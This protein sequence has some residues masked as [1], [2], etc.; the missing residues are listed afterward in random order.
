MSAGKDDESELRARME[1]L[2]G[3]IRAQRRDS[4]PEPAKTPGPASSSADAGMSMAMKAGSEFV[5]AIL[6]GAALG[7]GL[8]WVL[9]TKPL[10]LIVFFMLGV[11]AG[12]WNVIRATSPNGAH[13]GLNS[14]LSGAVAGDKD[15]PRTPPAGGDE[16]ED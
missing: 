8:D 15:V 11:A 9:H 5:A 1:R 4:I 7:W 16:D 10:F 6:V 12:V 2:S 13:K 3:A 14:R